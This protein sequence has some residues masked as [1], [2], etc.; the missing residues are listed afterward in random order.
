VNSDQSSQQLPGLSPAP[1]FGG[2]VEMNV[3]VSEDADDLWG[4]E[5]GGYYHGNISVT[6]A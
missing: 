6:A 3:S 1:V 2:N 4:K 5:T